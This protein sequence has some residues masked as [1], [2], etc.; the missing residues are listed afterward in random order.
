MATTESRTGTPTIDKAFDQF[1]ELNEQVVALA[2]ESGK[3]YVASC[4]KAAD[5]TIEFER[6]LA[7]TARQD[8]LRS[9]I[10]AQA[11][12]ARELTDSYTTM[13]RALLK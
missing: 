1:K 12:F 13:A 3:L 8:W 5:R 10:E 9:L 4:Q 6:K 2:R 11:D 7:G